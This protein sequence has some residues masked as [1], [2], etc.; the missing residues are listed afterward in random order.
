MHKDK[1][2]ILYLYQTF[3]FVCEE[4]IVGTPILYLSRLFQ[5]I[6]ILL[7]FIGTYGAWHLKSKSY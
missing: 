7:D 1:Y 5:S 2:F 6:F 4:N 3:K